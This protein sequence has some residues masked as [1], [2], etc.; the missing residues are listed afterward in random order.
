MFDREPTPFEVADFDWTVDGP[1]EPVSD[2]PWLAVTAGVCLV[3]LAVLGGAW[4]GR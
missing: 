3:A 1:A 4:L 2:W